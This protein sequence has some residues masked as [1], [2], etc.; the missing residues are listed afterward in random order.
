[1][2]GITDYIILICIL[3]APLFYQIE[4]PAGSKP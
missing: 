4:E 2:S 1:M 3:I